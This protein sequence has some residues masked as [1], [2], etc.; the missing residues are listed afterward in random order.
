MCPLYLTIQRK[1]SFRC[2]LFSVLSVGVGDD[3]G[4]DLL[5]GH[6]HQHFFVDPE[7]LEDHF[8]GTVIDLGDDED[9]LFFLLVVGCLH[10]AVFVDEGRIDL[11]FVIFEVGLE[12]PTPDDLFHFELAELLIVQVEEHD[13]PA[14]FLV[15]LDCLDLGEFLV[16]GVLQAWLIWVLLIAG[17]F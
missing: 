9:A 16:E 13:F 4:E 2:V 17:C 6:L 3:L 12:K 11:F 15:V 5:E 7:R 1:G 8:Q 14:I 10:V